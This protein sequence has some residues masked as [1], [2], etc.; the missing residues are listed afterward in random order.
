MFFDDLMDVNIRC[1]ETIDLQKNDV[2]AVNNE[3][4]SKIL[5][6]VNKNVEHKLVTVVRHNKKE[7]IQE[8]FFRFRNYLI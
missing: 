6:V 2:I 5:S 1:E 8:G 3:S 4:S 7:K